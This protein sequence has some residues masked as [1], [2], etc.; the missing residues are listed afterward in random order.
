MQRAAAGTRSPLLVVALASSLVLGACGGQVASDHP[1]K[2]HTIRMSGTS[3]APAEI[4]VAAGDR[5]TW[6]NEDYFPHTAT[7]EDGR[8]DSGAIAAG[9]SWT[10]TTENSGDFDYLCTFHPT[11]RGRLMVRAPGD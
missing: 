3:F 4:T 5:I 9:A 2:T 10:L 7:S 11:M 1:P 8:F 6:I